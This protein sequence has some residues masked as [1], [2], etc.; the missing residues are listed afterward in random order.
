MTSTFR[1]PDAHQAPVG[2]LADV[3]RVQQVGPDRFHAAHVYDSAWTLYGGQVAAQALAAASATVPPGASPTSVHVQFLR[4]GSSSLPVDLEVLRDRD[5][6]GFAWRRVIAT[7]GGRV[8]ATLSTTISLLSQPALDEIQPVRMP[9]VEPPGDVVRPPLLFETDLSVPTQAHPLMRYPTRF[10][11]RCGADLP[12]HVVLTYLSDLFTGHE[13]LPDAATRRTPTLDHSLWFHRSYAP[14]EWLLLDLASRGVSAGR[15]LYTGSVWR[16]TGT[17]VAS[18][19]QETLYGE[20]SSPSCPPAI[21]A[22]SQSTALRPA[23]H[24]TAQESP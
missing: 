13:G 19:A 18:L 22:G 23:T 10:W 7:Q 11:L 14:G 17:L 8:I 3:L 12:A 4:P 20:P 6:T 9:A 24:L 16:P 5:G 1:V 2:A 15:A 21:E